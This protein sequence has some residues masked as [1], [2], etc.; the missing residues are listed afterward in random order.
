MSLLW[1][2][3]HGGHIWARDACAAASAW[4]WCARSVLLASALGWPLHRN[5]LGPVHHQYVWVAGS[6]VRVQINRF[7]STTKATQ[8]C[9]I[10]YCADRAWSPG[11]AHL[12]RCFVR[13]FCKCIVVR[14]E[15]A[16]KSTRSRRIRSRG[17][18]HEERLRKLVV[19]R[20]QCTSSHHLLSH[21]QHTTEHRARVGSSHLSEVF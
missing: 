4:S 9:H 15:A 16:T 20:A 6:L 11:T 12:M 14:A 18:D 13:R 7:I 1:G 17:F 21:H 8:P 19:V 3:A 5:L 2:T 10:V